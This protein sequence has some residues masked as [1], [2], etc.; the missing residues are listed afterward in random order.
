MRQLYV[1]TCAG[2]EAL[3]HRR[4]EYGGLMAGPLGRS[5]H[6]PM[7]ED[8]RLRPGCRLGDD[9]ARTSIP[10]CRATMVSG[11]VDMPTKSVPATRRH[12]VSAGVS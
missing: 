4:D 2:S 11:A 1:C 3:D 9:T 7:I 8:A 10:M 6:V 5:Q 12:R